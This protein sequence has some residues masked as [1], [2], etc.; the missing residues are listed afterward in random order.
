MAQI[1]R[2][3]IFPGSSQYVSSATQMF[4]VPE[5]A[6]CGDA[7]VPRTTINLRD[8]YLLYHHESEDEAGRWYWLWPWR[9][10]WHWNWP[11]PWHWLW[12]WLLAWQWPWQV[13]VTPEQVEILEPYFPEKPRN[14]PEDFLLYD[15][16]DTESED[17]DMEESDLEDSTVEDSEREENYNDALVAADKKVASQY[18][19][20]QEQG[21]LKSLSKGEL[22]GTQNQGAPCI[23]EVKKSPG[24]PRKRA[25]V[26]PQEKRR[27][28]KRMYNTRGRLLDTQQNPF[29]ADAEADLG[30]VITQQKY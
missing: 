1:N 28:T 23:H 24:V 17:S 15:Y 19:F 30:D 11:W 6:D 4:P 26:D 13:Q 20:T 27:V 5:F 16:Y 18:S 21:E 9:W 3:H 14:E 22:G 29:G 2:R 25:W 10:N 7:F 12:H 8:Y